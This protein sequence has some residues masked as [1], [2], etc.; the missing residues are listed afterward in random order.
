MLNNIVRTHLALMDRGTQDV[1]I[2]CKN[3]PIVFDVLVQFSE[4]LELH[5]DQADGDDEQ[6]Q[7]RVD[8]ALDRGQHELVFEDEGHEAVREDVGQGERQTEGRDGRHHEAGYEEPEVEAA[9]AILE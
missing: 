1:I 4:L 2:S 7:A 8:P 3:L 5:D 9:E 6:Q